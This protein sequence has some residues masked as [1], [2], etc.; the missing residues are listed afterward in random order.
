VASLQSG[1]HNADVTCAVESVIT[2]TIG[3]LN[4]LIL[5]SLV[6]ELGWVDEVSGAKLLRP[7]LLAVVD[8]NDDNLASLSLNSTLND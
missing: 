3:H 1:T 6:A 8:I 5:D 7:L 2:T 4:Q